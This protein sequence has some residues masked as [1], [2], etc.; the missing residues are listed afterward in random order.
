M[1]HIRR[2]Q[3]KSL[4]ISGK[5]GFQNDLHEM[6]HILV[7]NHTYDPAL[8]GNFKISNLSALPQ[9]LMI[10]PYMF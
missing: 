10:A 5:K 4:G 6:M 2:S 9:I 8:I 3:H 1:V 7:V